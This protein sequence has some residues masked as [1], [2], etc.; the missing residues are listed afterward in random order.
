MVINLKKVQ[1]DDISFK[2]LKKTEKALK[3]LVKII[4]NFGSDRNQKYRNLVNNIDNKLKKLDQYEKKIDK[5]KEFIEKDAIDNIITSKTSS[6]N[7]ENEK[8]K[9]ELNN[10]V[11]EWGEKDITHQVLKDELEKIKDKLS[12]VLIETLNP[13]GKEVRKML[14]DPTF[15]LGVLEE[16]SIKAETEAK[17]N[18]KDLKSIIGLI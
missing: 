13:I 8:L 16:G 7:Q 9:K 2:D 11:I 5:I 3:N 6:L 14:E 1:D 10:K 4:N 15:I 17:K 12:E 18:L